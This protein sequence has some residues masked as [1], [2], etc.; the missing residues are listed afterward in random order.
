MQ[1]LVSVSTAT[2]RL[3][4]GRTQT[5]SGSVSPAHTGSIRLTIER[6]GRLL[7]TKTVALAETGYRFSYKPPRA[8]TY[9]VSASLGSDTDHLG[10]TSVWRT[11]RVSK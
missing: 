5:I 8:G 6:N 3:K 1:V 11:F 10:G 4:L 2:T 7:S 9:A